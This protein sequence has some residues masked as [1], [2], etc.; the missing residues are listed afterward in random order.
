MGGWLDRWMDVRLRES[1]VIRIHRREYTQ[2]GRKKLICVS[3]NINN[4]Q[5]DKINLHNEHIYMFILNRGYYDN[6]KTPFCFN[7]ILND[8]V[9]GENSIQLLGESS[10]RESFRRKFFGGQWGLPKL[11]SNVLL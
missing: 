3:L 10:N 4:F 2:V 7:D 6:G 1:S 11:W 8:P 9:K 5:V